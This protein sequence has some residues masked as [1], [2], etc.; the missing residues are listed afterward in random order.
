MPEVT[1]S[2]THL[3]ADD[4]FLYREIN[5]EAD[6]IEFQND[7]DALQEWER[8]WQMHFHPEKCQVIHICTNKSFYRHPTY[9]LHGHTLES[10]ENAKYLGVTLSE[11]L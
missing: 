7:L 2:D 9:K 10:V 6:Y 3:F 11:D 5:S 1:T 4:S 8:I